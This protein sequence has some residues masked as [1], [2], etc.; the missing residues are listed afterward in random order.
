MACA[1][2]ANNEYLRHSHTHSQSFAA[3]RRPNTDAS[4]N[5]HTAP[6]TP[7]APPPPSP[8]S[9]PRFPA[10][11]HTD[12]AA[13]VSSPSLPFAFLRDCSAFGCFN[14][15]YIIRRAVILQPPAPH[16]ARLALLDAHNYIAVPR[17]RMI[18]VKLA[19]H[20][21]AIGVRMIPADQIIFFS[22]AA[23]SAIRTSSGVTSNRFRGESF[24]LFSS[25][26]KSTTS[27]AAPAPSRSRPSIAPQHSYGYVSSPCAS[28]RRTNSFGTFNAAFSSP[29]T[30]ALLIPHS[31]TARSGI[32]RP[33]PAESSQ[34]PRARRAARASQLP[35]RPTRPRRRSRRP[36]SLPR[37][38]AA[39]QRN[40]HLLSSP[41]CLHP[42]ATRR[43]SSAQSTWPCAS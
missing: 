6:S 7:R 4:S 27:R 26:I 33:S 38:P 34:S 16:I 31:R 43:R 14:S 37:E 9:N 11:P 2:S 17:P 42:P 15:L 3:S 21:R 13:S 30:A 32:F 18:P 39:S 23:C 24:L 12:A 19:R 22:R 41:P 25:G 28:M 5:P 36:E 35:G 29:L 10:A 1:P 40:K 20:R 8:P